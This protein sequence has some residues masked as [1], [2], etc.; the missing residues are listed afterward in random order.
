MKISLQMCVTQQRG[1]IK[2]VTGLFLKRLHGDA[3]ADKRVTTIKL[4]VVLIPD[5]QTSSVSHRGKHPQLLIARLPRFGFRHHSSWMQ[6]FFFFFWQP[7][8]GVSL[9]ASPRTSF[10]GVPGDEP[11]HHATITRE[12]NKRQPSFNQKEPR[13]SKTSCHN[14]RN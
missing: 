6:L 14:E 7:S 5:H 1:K 4:C 11:L 12:K 9:N 2:R 3:A 8:V 13:V 10:R